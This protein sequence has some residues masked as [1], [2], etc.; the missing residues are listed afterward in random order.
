MGNGRKN[1]MGEGMIQESNVREGDM[2]K[3]RRIGEDSRRR[4]ND[5]WSK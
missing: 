4:E 3:M 1:D 5:N 2:E